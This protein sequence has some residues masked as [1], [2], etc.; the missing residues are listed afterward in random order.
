[1]AWDGKRGT[2][3]TDLRTDYNEQVSDADGARD[4][5]ETLIRQPPQRDAIT[6]SAQYLHDIASVESLPENRDGAD[7]T[8]VLTLAEELMRLRRNVARMR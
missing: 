2:W 3:Q 5:L 7:K 6:L 8:W 1:M 4:V